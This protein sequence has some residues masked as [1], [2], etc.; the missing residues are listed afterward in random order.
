MDNVKVNVI[1]EELQKL[2]A[3]AKNGNH[4]IASN[5]LDTIEQEV[6][7]LKQHLSKLS[8]KTRNQID[9]NEFVDNARQLT[10]GLFYEMTVKYL[11]SPDVECD[12]NEVFALRLIFDDL[13]KR[14]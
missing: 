8:E 4:K 5:S 7:K 14:D 2:K 1:Q 11:S 13:N 10:T 3:I 12:D 6:D 9:F